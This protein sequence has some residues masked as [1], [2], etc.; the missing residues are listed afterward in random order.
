MRRKP[1][2]PIT[3][4]AD[5]GWARDTLTHQEMIALSGI[6][7]R[8]ALYDPS[9]SPEWA[10][11]LIM[12]SSDYERLAEWV[13]PDWEPEYQLDPSELMPITKFIARTEIRNPHVVSLHAY[14]SLKA[15]LDHR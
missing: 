1:S 9:V 7:R 4:K 10:T 5:P 3:Y 15:T 8:W 2:A 13:G 11:E 14:K 12:W 6:F